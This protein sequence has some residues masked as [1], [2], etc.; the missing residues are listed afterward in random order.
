ME[1]GGLLGLIFPIIFVGVPLVVGLVGWFRS[2]AE[3]RTAGSPVPRRLT[4][5]SILL[6]VLAFNLTFFVQELFLVVPKALT[7]GLRPTLFHNN[8]NWAGTHPLENL[9]QGTGAA[10]ILLSGLVFAWLARRGAGRTEAS[11]LF[12]LWMAY[13]G[14]FQSL[15]QFAFAAVAAESDTGRALDWFGLSVTGE[16]LVAIMGAAAIILA[17]L[18]MTRRFLEL[19]PLLETGRAR[20]RFTFFAAVLPSILAIPVLILFRIPREWNEVVIPTIA[21]PLIGLIWVQANAWRTHVDPRAVA[22]SPSLAWP[23]G[24][25]VLLLLFFQLILRPG[26]PFY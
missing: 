9:F 1:H 2:R 7:P 20:T 22:S 26:I 16:L 13:N 15:P 19:A 24:L 21:V 6:Y 8:H 23:A 5:L 12:V 25:V 10:A 3:P 14:L 4:Q 17:G 11:R 18:F